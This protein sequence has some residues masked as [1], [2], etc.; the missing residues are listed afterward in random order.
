MPMLDE[1]DLMNE[2]T[3]VIG[4]V[5]IEMMSIM[6]RREESEWKFLRDH[7]KIFQSDFSPKSECCD[8]QSD[9]VLD[10]K[11]P[12]GEVGNPQKEFGQEGGI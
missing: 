5:M 1:A 6:F 12:S 4:S 3:G 2:M 9:L 8:T 11:T 7:Q 10:D